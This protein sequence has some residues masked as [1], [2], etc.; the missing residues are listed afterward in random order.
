[1]QALNEAIAEIPEDDSVITTLET[2][3]QEVE[4][5][6]KVRDEIEIVL[7]QYKLSQAYSNMYFTMDNLNQVHF[8]YQYSL[9]Y[10]LIS[11]VVCCSLISNWM[12]KQTII[13][14][15]QQ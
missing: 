10:F 8:L 15:L 14:V 4:E 7:R 5:T 6:D 12:E 3:K 1:M 9:K 2:L 11:S 13:T